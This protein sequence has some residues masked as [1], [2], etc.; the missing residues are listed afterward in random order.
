MGRWGAA[1]GWRQACGD[2]GKTRVNTFI[3][4]VGIALATLAGCKDEAARD[5][6]AREPDLET[7]RP[8]DTPSPDG[9]AAA[10]AGGSFTG[11]WHP[12]DAGANGGATDAGAREDALSIS[13][14][15]LAIQID[16]QPDP[17]PVPGGSGGS[18]GTGGAAEEPDAQ[19]AAPL[20]TIE[21]APHAPTAMI[22]D[23]V[24]FT[25]TLVASDGTRRAID[26]RVT[27]QS[28]NPDVATVDA[29]GVVTAIALGTT[30][31][32]ARLGPL[33]GAQMLTV[34]PAT[35]ERL[36][37]SPPAATIGVGET[38]VFKAI[39]RFSN[40]Q[41]LD[42][43]N[44]VTWTS[45]EPEVAGVALL[46]GTWGLATA[47]GPGH[48][49]IGFLIFGDSAHATLTVVDRPLAAKR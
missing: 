38:Q 13:S 3:A 37:I 18:D 29:H 14:V 24:T 39:A 42:I 26:H 2:H 40:G 32:S 19:P 28:S 43:T 34:A 4:L 23:L 6:A 10:H 22:A 5:P 25:A 48:T 31:I 46:P 7:S 17:R 49:E 41:T 12:A 45:S 47:I 1:R 8:Y 35:V 9:G 20:L 21:V 33:M 11:A 15:D 44:A 27:W 30:T 36:L 16:P